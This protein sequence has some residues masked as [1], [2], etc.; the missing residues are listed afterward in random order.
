MS[1][2]SLRERVATALHNR[3]C[4]CSLPNLIDYEAA[5]AV[6]AEVREWLGSDE[7]AKEIDQAFYMDGDTPGT[8]FRAEQAG[9][10]LAALIA[11]TKEGEA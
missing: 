6:L 11:Q 7:V 4:P 2:G 8:S 5:D 3:K 10:N 9:R 1:A